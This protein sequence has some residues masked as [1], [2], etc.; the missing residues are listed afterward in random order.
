MRQPDEAVTR[1]W[2]RSWKDEAEALLAEYEGWPTDCDLIGW[3]PVPNPGW[4]KDSIVL[5]VLSRSSGTRRLVMPDCVGT[6]GE[7]LHAR[8][9]E[10]AVLKPMEFLADLDARLARWGRDLRGAWDEMGK[11]D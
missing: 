4:A 2:D 10:M 11:R 7:L 6:A 3:L 8:R 1:A 9:G 5:A